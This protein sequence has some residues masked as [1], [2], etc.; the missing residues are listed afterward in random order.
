MGL[1]LLMVAFSSQCVC[2]HVTNGETDHRHVRVVLDLD[3]GEI[4]FSQAICAHSSPISLEY[5]VNIV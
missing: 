2:P 4:P 3:R 1:G 5:Y